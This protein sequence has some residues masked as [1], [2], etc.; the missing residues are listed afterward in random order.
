MRE[1]TTVHLTRT[2]KVTAVAAALV[3][4]AAVGTT[5]AITAG[6]TGTGPSYFACLKSGR[7]SSVGTNAPT[8]PSGGTQISWD[9]QGP[10]GTTGSTGS[11]GPVGQSSVVNVP[12]SVAC[13]TPGAVTAANVPETYLDIPGIPGEST[14]PSFLNQISVLSWSL[15]GS[16]PGSSSACGHPNASSPHGDLTVVKSIDKASPGLMLA[17]SQG[18]NLGTVTLTEV[19]SKGSGA[20][21]FL[22]TFTFKLV[23]VK[24]ISWSHDDESPKETITF[25]YGGLSVRYQSANP[26][27]TLNPAV[28]TCFDFNANNPC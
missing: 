16:G 18:T 23:V 7:L 15:G 12:S 27:G 9:A 22:L 6:A 10:P 17:A 28:A 3:L 2:M 4:V 8:C 26:D 24:T 14:N 11:Q 5:A 21:S 19:H 1:G 25:E 13:P 20:G